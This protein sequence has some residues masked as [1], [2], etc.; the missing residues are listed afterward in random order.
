LLE[1][2]KINIFRDIFLILVQGNMAKAFKN[3]ASKQPYQS[4]NQISIPGFESPFE[5]NLVPDNR[6][7]VLARKIPWDILVRTYQSQMENSKTGANGI[8]PRVAIG[9]MIIKHLCGLSDRETVLQILENVY[10]Q[11]LIGYNSF[12]TE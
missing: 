1:A 2:N 11:H 9:A 8:N 3:R 6:W 7:V 10:M 12:S 5:K 4:Q